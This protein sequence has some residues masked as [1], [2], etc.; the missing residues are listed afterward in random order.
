MSSDCW[1]PNRRTVIGTAVS[2]VVLALAGCAGG[3]GDGDD[4]SQDT[5]S[6][7]DEGEPTDDDQQTAQ[8]DS[9][10]EFPDGEGCP[11]CNMVPSEHSEWNAQLVGTDGT[12]VYTCSSGCMLAYTADPEHFGGADEEIENVWVTDYET[13][14]LIDG[15]ESY[16]VRVKD[17]NHVDDIMKKNP[18]PFA[19]RGDAEAFI[20]ELNDEFDA[21]YQ[22]DVD[23][24]T[25]DEF[26]MELAT[27]YRGGSFEN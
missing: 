2:G 4:T 11:V 16:Y 3:S 15:Q 12:R 27:F 26:D 13:G 5:E 10:T 20:D 25:F 14:D 18:T 8:L 6:E 24:I 7:S 9:P 1:H 23:V 21:D 19:E 22:P 17:S